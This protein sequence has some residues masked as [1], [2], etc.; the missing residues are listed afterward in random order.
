MPTPSAQ[1]G[2]GDTYV[3]LHQGQQVLLGGSE[4]GICL[5]AGDRLIRVAVRVVEDS[6]GGLC[7]DHT[8][9]GLEESAD[10]RSEGPQGKGGPSRGTRRA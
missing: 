9:L 7:D 8:L 6:R 10:L 2:A 1:P 4:D 3:Q 5:R